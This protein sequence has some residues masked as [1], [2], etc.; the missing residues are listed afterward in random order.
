MGEFATCFKTQARSHICPAKLIEVSFATLLLDW[1]KSAHRDLPWRKTSDPYAIWVSEIMLQQTRVTAV[2]PYYGRFLE[3]FPDVTSLAAAS[4]EQFLAAWAGLG[5]YSRVRNMHRAS[6]TIGSDGFPRTYDAIRALPGI[7]DYTA[8]AIASIAFGLPHAAV[9]GNVLRVLSRVTNDAGDIGSAVV[10]NRLREVAGT[11]LDY[12]EP[13]TFNQAM[14]ELG[15]TICLP[16]SPMCLQCPV[17]ELCQARS[18]GTQNELPIKAPK[19]ETVRKNRRVFV[20][21]SDAGLLMWQRRNT[22]EKLVGFWELPEPEHFCRTP[23]GPQAKVA[24]K[25]RHAITNHLYTFEVCLVRISIR[26]TI[27]LRPEIGG[28]WIST[29][30]LGSVVLSTTTRKA[31]RLCSS[32]L[33][34]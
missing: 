10:Q 23:L 17:S 6:R 2:I 18:E 31:L 26:N 20:I 21:Q 30:E 34:L 14:M 19:A 32:V 29:A 8:S 3:S 22:T 28:R 11:L 12:N 9:D 1:Y 25:F 16:R 33:Q 24:G 5:Y 7:G 15:A 27:E 4:E 13:G